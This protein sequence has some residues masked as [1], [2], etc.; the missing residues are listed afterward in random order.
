METSTSA[1]AVR[2]TEKDGIARYLGVPFADPPVRFAA[3]VPRTPWEG[4]RDCTSPGPTAPQP[5]RTFGPL[6]LMPVIGEARS[7]EDYLTVD[8]WTPGGTDLPVMVF[9]HGGAF[10]AGGPGAPAYDG[11]A[12]AR[13]GV[14]LVSV[15]YRLGIEG[16]LPVGDTNVGLR[17]QVAASS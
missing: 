10:V 13:A 14:V 8:V 11:T 9:L 12:L 15:T 5:P 16:F 17:D 6:D 3:P 1:G 7:G 2:G 4:V